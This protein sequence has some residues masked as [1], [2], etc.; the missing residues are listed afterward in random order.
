MVERPL[1]DGL[2]TR[3]R[4]VEPIGRGAS[5]RVWRARDSERGTDVA[6]KVILG[7]TGDVGLRIEREA[8]ALA[9]LRGVEGVLRVHDVGVSDQGVGWIASDL[10]PGG[11]LADHFEATD[12]LEPNDGHGRRTEQWSQDQLL[13]FGSRLA[14]ALAALHE[15]GVLHGDLSPANILLGAS[16]EPWISDFGHADLGDGDRVVAG[17]TPAYAAP[18]RLRGSPASTAADVYSAAVLLES[19]GLDLHCAPTAAALAPRPSQRPSAARLADALA[20]RLRHDSR[21]PASP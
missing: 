5:A 14:A 16:N 17:F 21:G 4:L 11:S 19:A 6:V 12:H 15:R 20:Y 1:I 8:R 3:I 2:P 18:E 13:Q 9:R 7:S 10:A